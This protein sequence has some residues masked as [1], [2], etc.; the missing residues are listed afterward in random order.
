MASA[1]SAPGALDWDAA[2]Q[3]ARPVTAPV[4]VPSTHPLYVL[5]TSGTTGTPKGIVRDSG[6][7]ATVGL[8]STGR[9]GGS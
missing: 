8:P 6:G 5:Y 9:A 2:M 4:S 7:Y 1:A 3:Q